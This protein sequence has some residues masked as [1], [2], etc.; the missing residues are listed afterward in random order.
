M[1]REILVSATA[2]E[3]W[4]ALL[5]DDELVEVMFDRPDQDRLVGDIFLGRVEAV[6]PGIQ[7]AF[8]DIGTGKAGFLHVADLVHGDE[9]EDDDSE[10]NGNGNSGRGNGNGRG[11]R[12]RQRKLPPIQ[13]HLQKGQD[14]LV[15]VTKEAIGT[16]GPRLTAQIS[17]PG[18][19]LVYIPHSSRVGV[20]RKIEGREQRS[21]LRKMAQAILPPN[22]G[23]IIVRTVSEE[24]NQ[25][26]LEKEFSR[27]HERWTKIERAARAARA[28][29]VVHREAKLVSGV[30]R[31]LFSD[32]FESLRVDSKEV[33]EE[34]REYVRSV[35][36]DLLERVH[37][38]EGPLSLFDEY[39][40]EEE[41]QKAFQRTVRL[42]SG[43]H[44]VIEPTE[45]LVSIDV[46]TGKFTGKGKKDPEQT[47]LRTNLEAARAI[48]KQLRL[49]DIGGI[50]V[51]DFID[52]E[53]QE[54]RDKVIREL[55]SCL[56]RD[57]ARTKAYEVSELGLVQMTRQRIRPSL[58]TSLTDV[59]PSC[60]GIG[61]VYK[62]ATV[63]RRIERSLQRVAASRQEKRIVVRVHPE[64]ALRVIENEPGLLNRLRS[65]TRLDL[66]MRDDPM[67]RLD[68]FRLLAGPA[69]TDVTEKY[70]AA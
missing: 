62:P 39:G 48:S 41:L 21:K 11:G 46:N 15:Q 52:M 33:Y 45:A 16:K 53:S 20:S 63:V 25:K 17:L 24:V 49:R 5:E 66:D 64:V 42:K 43:G 26:T 55:R 3:S 58:F 9:S 68:E 56:A 18:R 60:G 69:E 22:S 19:F 8:V 47:I 28:P 51:V 44:I 57:R 30:I 13:D 29:A 34:V 14:I 23:G 10:G 12:R 37:L 67:M 36:P 50:I 4:V 65:R 31:D 61:R 35:D 2:Q 70:V 27:L 38:H 1:R 6:L 59:C 54:S 7:A 32:K 40:I